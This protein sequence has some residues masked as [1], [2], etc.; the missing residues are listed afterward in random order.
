MRGIAADAGG[1]AAVVLLCWASI[2]PVQRAGASARLVDGG[3]EGSARTGNAAPPRDGQDPQESKKPSQQ[4]V[5]GEV[6]DRDGTPVP[7]AEVVFG[8]PKKQAVRTNQQ[9]VF[10]FTG[11]AGTYTV[12]VNAGKRHRTFTNVKIDNNELVPNA[13][14]IDR[15]DPEDQ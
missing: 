5:T 2:L 3:Q 1:M 11:P 15:E 4:T 13:F 9:G 8:G 14:T 10:T 12:T 6:T 7:S